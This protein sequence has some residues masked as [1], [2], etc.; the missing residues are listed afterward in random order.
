MHHLGQVLWH[1]RQRVE[2]G[3]DATGR[4]G[5]AEEMLFDAVV[6][7]AS[8][9]IPFLDHRQGTH[10][11]GEAGVVLSQRVQVLLV[12]LQVLGQ[13][14]HLLCQQAQ[15][16]SDGIGDAQR[17]VAAQPGAADVQSTLDTAGDAAAGPCPQQ[18]PRQSGGDRY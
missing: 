7:F 10:L 1:V 14:V 2:E 3:A 4:H 18:Q 6:Q 11:I 13:Q 15:V 17:E 8:Q 16:I 9:S 12:V 5:Q